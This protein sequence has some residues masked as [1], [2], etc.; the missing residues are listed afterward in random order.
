MAS[1]THTLQT[2]LAK[3]HRLAVF[4]GSL[5]W[6]AL[7]LL[8]VLYAAMH[9]GVRTEWFRARVERELS[10]LTGM[11]MRVGRIRA[12][13][14]LNLKIRDVISLTQDAGLELRLVRVRWR[15]LRPRNAP[16]IESIRVDGWAATL[17][18]DADG[19]MQPAGLGRLPGQI[20]GWAGLQLPGI[21]DEAPP[22]DAEKDAKAPPPR[23]P[24]AWFAI[25]NLEMRWG[26]VRIQ[27]ANGQALAILSG[28]DVLRTTMIL[29]EGDRITHY[30]FRA[31]LVQVDQGPRIA[32]LQVE[33]IDTGDRQF[34]STLQATDWG[35]APRPPNTEDDVRALLDAMD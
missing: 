23:R 22:A 12:T 27:D 34:V 21:S 28:L 32:G 24:L 19:R 16:I 26:S 13:E 30:E 11:E 29:P 7:L 1:G 35:A 2:L 5:V 4:L 15:L 31:G 9:L 8:I 25:G 10:A 33:L 20:L 18:P 3:T 17:A 14:S 6:K